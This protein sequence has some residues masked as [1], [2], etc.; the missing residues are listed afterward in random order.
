MFGDV[1]SIATDYYNARYEE[2][3]YPIC[4]EREYEEDEEY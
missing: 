4:I 2:Y 1:E 3:N